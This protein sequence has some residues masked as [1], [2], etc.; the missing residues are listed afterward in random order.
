MASD[1]TSNAERLLPFIPFT[2]DEEDWHRWSRLF[3]VR[4]RVLGYHGILEGTTK[5]PTDDID[6]DTKE[7]KSARKSN[8]KAYMDLMICCLTTI[9]FSCVDAAKTPEIS[10]G[11]A[12]K[13]WD[14]LKSRFE[15]KTGVS[16]IFLKQCF[17][18]SALRSNQ[19]PDE[20]FLELDRI[21]QLLATN[22]KNHLTDEDFIIHIIA[23]LPKQYE[24]LIINF[25]W[26]LDNSSATLTVE[27]LKAQIRSKYL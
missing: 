20:W 19:Y 27:T 5:N 23:K 13:S 8:E 7:L 10:E 12:K 2:G 3:L 25:E 22:F 17:A 24:E 9:P 18:N 6:L 4:A 21:K 1:S 14:N 15:P 11:D 16:K 26:Q